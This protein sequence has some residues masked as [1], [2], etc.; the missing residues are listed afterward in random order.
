MRVGALAGGERRGPGIWVAVEAPGG[1]HVQEEL[2]D[3]LRLEEL[4]RH[5]RRRVDVAA[6]PEK[7]V[8]R[9]EVQVGFSIDID[10]DLETLESPV[11]RRGIIRRDG[12]GTGQQ[13]GGEGGG[14][15]EHHLVV[16]VLVVL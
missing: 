7:R 10:I 8:D 9:V 15:G 5:E 3:V 2:E 1:R 12:E 16:L 13:R 14:D 6:R 11:H 4:R